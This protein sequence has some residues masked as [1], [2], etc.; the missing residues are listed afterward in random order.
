MKKL[1]A[2]ILTALMALSPLAMAADLGDYPA[3]LA[4]DGVLDAYVVVGADADPADV[5]GAVDV[6]AR[7]AAESYTSVTT[8][9]TISVSG[10]KTEDMLLN[11]ALNDATAFGSALDDDDLPGFFDG[12]VTINNLIGSTT[13]KDNYDAH[14][15]LRLTGDAILETGLTA[16]SPHEDFKSET[17]I[18]IGKSSVSYYFVFDDSLNNGNY[19]ANTSDDYPVELE[20]LGR[21]LTISGSSTDTSMTVQSGTEYSLAVGESVTVDG[22]TISLDNVGSSGSIVVS[23]DGVSG[24]VSEGGQKVINGVTVKN[25]EAFYSTEK[26]DRSAVILVGEDV[27][28][29]VTDG[30]A[31]CIGSADKTT[32]EEDE[33]WVWDLSGLSGASPVI[34]VVYNQRLDEYDEVIGIGKEFAFPHDYAKVR[35]DSYVEN[36]YKKYVVESDE[37]VDLYI[38]TTSY[39][40][41][42]RTIH[43]YG[44]GA[45]KDS[46]LT[47]TGSHDTDDLYLRV[48]STTNALEVFYKDTSDNKVKYLQAITAA[49]AT[50]YSVDNVASLKY[51]DTDLDLDIKWVNVST[52]LGE[53]K[54]ILNTTNGDDI[55][56][57]F[58]EDTTNGDFRY[59]GETD[60][61]STYTNDLLYGTRDISGWEEDTRTENGIVIFDPKAHLSG[62]TFEF[63]VNGDEGD[64]KTNVVILGPSGSASGSSGGDI[65]EVV[66][67]TTA[68]AKLDTEISDPATAG[69]DLVLVGG[70]AV[71]RLTAQAMDLDY[72]TYGGSGLLPIVEGQGYVEYA[73]DAFTSGQDVVL[74]FGWAA[75]DTRK[76]TSVLQQVDS[77]TSDLSGN[78]AVVVTDVSSAGITP[79]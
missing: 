45:S 67:V 3:F 40:T 65:K 16:T 27:S 43:I 74:V 52:T 49:D 71:N 51:Q 15:E 38:G 11:L 18:E 24:T 34:G 19:I 77:F 35:L 23:V 68:I 55:I 32:C 63:D 64:F 59:L 44:E 58:E 66:P 36:D 47:T 17:F 14:D 28:D 57:D 22:L 37:V 78:M 42:Q 12:K 48:N 2:A 8:G 56:I 53:G 1:V 50:D 69:K 21:T 79:V 33:I 5:V 54:I 30:D 76:A 4:E 7:L 20:F 72:P 39:A 25:K 41:S 46:L 9:G 60:G 6:A 61:D 31:Y 13:Y 75:A 10:G 73:P 26:E 70:P 29:T 62:D